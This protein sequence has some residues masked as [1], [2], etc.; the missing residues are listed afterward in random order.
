MYQITMEVP[1]ETIVNGCSKVI[2]FK[3]EPITDVDAAWRVFDKAR[4]TASALNMENVY[5]NMMQNGT[6]VAWYRK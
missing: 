3:S 1:E 2:T 6:L 4:D 5:V